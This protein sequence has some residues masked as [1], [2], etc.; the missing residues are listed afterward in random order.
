MLIFNKSIKARIL[1]AVTEKI[2]SLQKAHDEKIKSLKDKHEEEIQ[3]KIEKHEA[4]L[5]EVA[6]EI[7]NN[8]LKK[9]L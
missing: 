4:S 7:V 5:I 9:I 6:D 1:K 3:A 2:D 8:F